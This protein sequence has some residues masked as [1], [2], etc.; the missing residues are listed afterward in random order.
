MKISHRNIVILFMVIIVVIV[1]GA[2]CK[3]IQNRR[4]EKSGAML[5]GSLLEK[6]LNGDDPNAIYFAYHYIRI[7]SNGKITSPEKWKERVKIAL[8]WI[9]EQDAKTIEN[10]VKDFPAFIKTM[11][12]YDASGEQ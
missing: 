5:R 12:P 6:Y 11:S 9:E 2:G 10:L 7:K 1:T 3:T 4:N 8:D